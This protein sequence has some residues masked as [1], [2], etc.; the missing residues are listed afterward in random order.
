MIS[1]IPVCLFQ[2][3]LSWLEAFDLSRTACVCTKWSVH[4][5]SNTGWES[6]VLS[7]WDI[8]IVTGR[9]IANC[10]PY[11]IAGRL[12][13]SENKREVDWRTRYR[14]LMRIKGNWKM[15]KYNVIKLCGHTE[16]ITAVCCN[17]D[18]VC[19]ASRDMTI[20]IWDISTRLCLHILRGHTGLISV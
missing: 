1:S 15:G 11:E 10:H 3:I 17:A 12:I 8:S 6:C 7:R 13:E 16:P 9:R 4:S 18:F 14:E 5:G 20:R 19:S 2:F